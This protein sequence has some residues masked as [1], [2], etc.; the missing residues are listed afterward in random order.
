MALCWL[1][2]YGVMPALTA[3]LERV[4]LRRHQREG[5]RGHKVPFTHFEAPFVWIV[6]RCPGVTLAVTLAAGVAALLAGGRYLQRGALEYNVRKLRSDPDTTSEVYRVSHI[7]EPHPGGQRLGRHDRADR[8]RPRHAAGR[9]GAAP[10][11]RPRAGE[12]ASVP[13]RAHAG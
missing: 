7:S 6:R 3:L 8:R 4:R 2:T 9:G 10:R 5:V 11:A 12:P 1:S 13:G